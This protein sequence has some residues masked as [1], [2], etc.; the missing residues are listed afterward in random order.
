[1]R[2]TRSTGQIS[3][4]S[5]RGT[6]GERPEEWANTRSAKWRYPDVYPACP[7]SVR[8]AQGEILLLNEMLE[9]EKLSRG[10]RRW[11]YLRKKKLCRFIEDE[12]YRVI[13][14]LACKGQQEVNGVEEAK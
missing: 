7:R 6:F 1:M 9:R 13:M 11:V 3:Y 12:D 10:E 14:R 5:G 4:D 2:K 8:E